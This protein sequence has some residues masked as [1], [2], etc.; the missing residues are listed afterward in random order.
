VGSVLQRLELAE[1]ELDQ[2]QTAIASIGQ[3]LITM[4]T[5]LDIIEDRLD[6]FN[7]SGDSL[8]TV[9][10]DLNTLATDLDARV[11]ALEQVVG[12]TEYYK[13]VFACFDNPAVTVNE[14]LLLRGDN[15][16]VRGYVSTVTQNGM[17]TIA[18]AGVSGHQFLTTNTS[19][20]CNLRIYDRTMHLR[21]CWHRTQ[22]TANAALID[23]QC[24]ILTP[25]VN[26][27]CSGL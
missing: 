16:E 2:V 26:C 20:K 22:R 10:T 9:I 8:E 19:P 25:T 4:E 27:T 17:G 1:V 6:N 24:D 18:V 11:G 23:A 3:E 14:P 21:I 12:G 5:T 13:W 15:K 7:G